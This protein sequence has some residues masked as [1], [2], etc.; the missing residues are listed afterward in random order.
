MKQL[1]RKSLLFSIISTTA[2]FLTA[3]KTTEQ[4]SK[5]VVDANNENILYS[6][7][8]EAI[9]NSRVTVGYSGARERIKFIGTSISARIQDDSEEN[10][11]AI[12]IDN[13][14]IGKTRLNSPDKTYLL[15]K[16]LPEG[17]HT[18]EVVRI[19]ECQFG[20]T[21]F[22]GF[23]LNEGAEILEWKPEYDRKIEFI[24]DSITCGYGVEANDPNLHFDAATEN[25]CL[26][27][28]GLTA[29]T[30]KADY[31]VVSRSGIGMFRN[32][33]G[34]YNGSKDTMPD[35]Y[36]YLYYLNYTKKWDFSQY[37]PDVVCINLG[38]NDFST[39]GVN[40]DRYVTTYIKFASDVLTRYPTAK[41]VILQGPMNN[42]PELN[43][44]LHRVLSKLEDTFPG[45]AS[46]FELSAQG[47]LGMGADYHPNI[48][49]SIKNAG[50][51]TKYL[52]QLMGWN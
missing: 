40:V 20:L 6:G 22:E 7:R 17:E 31:L 43:K 47:E 21:H 44:A 4:A 27:Y 28:S 18:A 41:L 49:Q 38:T 35:I 23:I 2:L 33:D 36:P 19:T 39:D 52:S 45:R 10:Y 50:E 24:G 37:T 14:L 13:E 1:L 3:C 29:R 32:Y 30:L 51:L 16:D 42:S 15:A 48:K 9:D 5:L 34:S 12:W 8:Y 25:F 26:N 46:Y 11:I